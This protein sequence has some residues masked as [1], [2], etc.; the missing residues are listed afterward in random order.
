MSDRGTSVSAKHITELLKAINAGVAVQNEEKSDDE[1]VPGI[2][3]YLSTPFYPL[4]HS[5]VERWFSTFGQS[6]RR[7]VRE[8]PQDWHLYAG[9]ICQVLNNTRCRATGFTPN[10][11]HI[12][13]KPDQAYPDLFNVLCDS[14]PASRSK[15]IDDRV[16]EIEIARD[17]AFRNQEHYFHTSDQQWEKSHVAP[18]REHNFVPGEYVLVKRLGRSGQNIPKL[19]GIPAY[20]GP[21]LVKKL[22]GRK[23]VIV[24]Y[25]A[26][27]QIRIRNYKHLTH[28]HEPEGKIAESQKEY[29][30]YY[31]GPG[32][33]SNADA[34]HLYE[35]ILDGDMETDRDDFHPSR[36]DYVQDPS[37]IDLKDLAKNFLTQEEDENDIDDRPDDEFQDD[38]HEFLENVDLVNPYIEDDEDPRERKNIKEDLAK[39][40]FP[41]EEEPEQVDDDDKRVIIDETKNKE[42][43][44]NDWEDVPENHISEDE[45]LNKEI[46]IA[47]SEDDNKENW[48]DH[49]S[50]DEELNIAPSEDDDDKR[51]DDNDE[52]LRPRRSPRQRNPVVY[53]K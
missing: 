28:F 52:S 21:A 20:L 30:K 49:E 23:A 16:R 41:E 37:K 2:K 15:F 40:L 12:G 50:E 18:L 7:L 19:P 27:G 33:R 46:I 9:R 1:Q 47:P 5:T 51:E 22:I 4:S 39:I 10:H 13:L 44:T 34:K 53:P 36:I 43:I 35:Q 3:Q 29:Q 45:E 26:N 32:D 25:I 6:L 31:N 11:L 8:R 42:I 48:V 14:P 38:Y 17:M 24:E